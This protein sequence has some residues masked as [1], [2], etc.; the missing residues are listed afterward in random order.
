MYAAPDAELDDGLLDV[1]MCAD[2]SK[3]QFLKMLRK[4]FKGTHVHE[5]NVEVLRS[6]TVRVSADRPFVAYADGDPIGDL[7][8]T[9][10]AVPHALDVLCPS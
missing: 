2:M 7:P 10:R 3:L 6:S 4:V 9:I 1:V 5:P 8:L